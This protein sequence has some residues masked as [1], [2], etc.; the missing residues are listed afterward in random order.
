M[1]RW[2][3]PVLVLPG[4]VLVLMP[5]LIYR[6]TRATDLTAS[7]A[8]GPES[9]SFWLAMLFGMPGAALSIWAMSMFFR[10]GDGTAAPWDPPQRLVVVGPYRHV[11]NPMLTGVIAIL[12]AESLLLQS[13]P[14]GIWAT[15]FSIGNAIYFPLVE[16]PGLL[17]RFGD[18][19]RV[20]CQHVGRWIPRLSPWQQPERVEVFPP[21]NNRNS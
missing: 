3:I 17:A 19:Y 5:L 1:S 6:L 10:F 12:F 18:D 2:I 21:P 9:V 13:W 8:A 20:Y 7:A 4:T 16:E 14:I 15:V 11:R